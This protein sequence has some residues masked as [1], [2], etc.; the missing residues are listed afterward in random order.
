MCIISFNKLLTLFKSVI[1]NSFRMWIIDQSHC[2]GTC[3]EPTIIITVNDTTI[4]IAH[5]LI[6]LYVSNFNGKNITGMKVQVITLPSQQL[7]MLFGFVSKAECVQMKNQETKCLDE[8]V[9]L[10]PQSNVHSNFFF[11]FFSKT[12][13]LQLFKGDLLCLFYS[14]DFVLEVDQ[15]RFL[16]FV[17][18]V[19]A[20]LF[21]PHRF[22]TLFANI[23]WNYD[24]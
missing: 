5:F 10:C 6:L 23:R 11:F 8:N 21:Q 2:L 24:F 16:L 18:I 9:Q 20:P 14:L 19:A 7:V 22:M 3:R 1:E 13:Q 12:G 4:Q 17:Y 15:N